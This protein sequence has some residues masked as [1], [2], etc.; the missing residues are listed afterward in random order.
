MDAFEIGYSSFAIGMAK[1]AG[2]LDTLDD[3]SA[4]VSRFSINTDKKND[5]LD[6]KLDQLIAMNRGRQAPASMPQ[7]K[8][9][10]IGADPAAKKLIKKK[11]RALEAALREMLR[12]DV[13]E[14]F[15]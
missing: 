15:D 1:Q 10:F 6:A 9:R 7:Q 13:D 4:K 12:D 2:L 8:V 5:D 3:I 11:R 14:D